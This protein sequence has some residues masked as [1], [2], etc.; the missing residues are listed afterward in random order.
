MAPRTRTFKYGVGLR[1]IGMMV[2]R[3]P[4]WRA[5]TSGG[6][7][8]NKAEAKGPKPAGWIAFWGC[9]RLKETS[10]AGRGVAIRPGQAAV[11]QPISAA[12]KW[13]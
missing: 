10:P 6:F 5:A 3:C 11:P 1:I 12:W 2:Y 7:F 9:R 4:P 13:I 8:I